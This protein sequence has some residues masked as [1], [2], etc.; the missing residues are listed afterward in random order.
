MICIVCHCVPY[1]I[2]D[3]CLYNLHDRYQVSSWSVS[4]VTVY[5]T[6]SM[7]IAF[8]T[9]IIGIKCRHDL[10][11]VSLCTLHDL[12]QLPLYLTW[13]VSSV[14]MICIMCHCVPYMIYDNCLYILHDRY[15]VSSWSVSCVTVY[16]TWSVSSVVMIVMI[17]IMIYDLWQLPLYLTW[18]VSSVVRNMSEFLIVF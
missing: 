15:Q 14:V 5:L 17:C 16:F 12:W 9:Y 2:Y 1:M 3:N 7:T 8:I 11:H 13:S 6:W 4:Y 18:S 10:C